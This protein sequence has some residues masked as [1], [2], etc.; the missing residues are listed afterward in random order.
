MDEP[1]DDVYR[2]LTDSA[3]T[4]LGQFDSQLEAREFAAGRKE[5]PLVICQHEGRWTVF[6]LRS[7]HS[8]SRV[9]AGH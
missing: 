7:T 9:P 5:N 6:V 8:T 4:A 2:R 3:S 1:T